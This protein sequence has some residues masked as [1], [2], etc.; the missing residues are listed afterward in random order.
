M[1]VLR[2]TVHQHLRTSAFGQG[3]IQSRSFRPYAGHSFLVSYLRR[4]E[5][6][7]VHRLFSPIGAMRFD[8]TKTAIKIGA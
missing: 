8:G 7:K 5:G 4:A 2:S 1:A 3:T 6:F